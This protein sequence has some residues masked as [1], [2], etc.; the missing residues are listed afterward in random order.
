MSA[1]LR[2]HAKERAD[3]SNSEGGDELMSRNRNDW[4]ELP[5]TPV[6]FKI[7]FALIVLG[8]LGFAGVL[9]WAVITLVSWVVAR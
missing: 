6:G 4:P 8:S 3:E 7:G 9:V 1:S 5:R 2:S